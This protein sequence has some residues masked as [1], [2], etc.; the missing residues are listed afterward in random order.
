MFNIF[1]FKRLSISHL[2]SNLRHLLTK[3]QSKCKHLAAKGDSLASWGCRPLDCSTD[4]FLTPESRRQVIQVFV[5]CGLWSG[6][7]ISQFAGLPWPWDDFMCTEKSQS[8]PGSLLVLNV[9]FAFCL[10]NL[11]LGLLSLSCNCRKDSKSYLIDLIYLRHDILNKIPLHGYF[12]DWKID[13]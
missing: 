8:E 10:S 4:P 3:T 9:L 12:F 7:H 6:G 13:I 5:F 2:Y 11:S 1:Y